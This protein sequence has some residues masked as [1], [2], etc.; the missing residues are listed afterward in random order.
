MRILEA[1]GELLI[2]VLHSASLL[3][4]GFAIGVYSF[5]TQLAARKRLECVVIRG[6]ALGPVCGVMQS[7]S[8]SITLL[9]TASA[10]CIVIAMAVRAYTS[11]SGIFSTTDVATC[12]NDMD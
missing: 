3:I 6:D 7:Y 1:H 9:L 2:D 12:N 8:S 4:F 5:G 11:N 10:V